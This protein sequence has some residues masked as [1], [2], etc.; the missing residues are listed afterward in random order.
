MTTLDILNVFVEFPGNLLFFLLVIALSQGSLFLA[1]GHRSRFPFEQATRRYV[2]A[3]SGL[4]IL[5]LIML[6][7]AFLTQFSALDANVYMPPMERLVYAITLLILAWCFLSADFHRWQN[8]S[9]LLVFGAAFVLVLLY[10]NSARGW[11]SEYA[12]GMA[13][14]ATVAAQL[15]SGVAAALAGFCALLAILN[16]KHIVD[17]PLKALFFFVFIIGNGWDFYQLSISDIAGNYLGAARL[18]YLAGLILL[19]VIIYRLSIALLEHSLVE[20]VLAASQ[21]NPAVAES[22]RPAQA[23]AEGEVDALLAAPSSWNFSASPIPSDRRHLLNAIGIMLETGEGVSVPEQ[24]VQAALETLQV[25]ICALLHFEENSYA[26]VIAG[27]DRVAEQSLSGVSLNLNEQPTLREAT[28]RREQTIL[29]PEYHAEELKDLYRRLSI[30][31]SSGVYAQP[32]TVEGEMVALMLVAMPYRQADLS[33]EE[34]ESLREIGYVAA[35]LLAWS[36]D[37][38]SSK[39]ITEEGLIDEIASKGNPT[40]IDQEVLNAYRHELENSLESVRDRRSRMA[41][42][43]VELKQQQEEQHVRLLDAISAGD[44]GQDMAQRLNATFD[45]QSQLRESFEASAR[46]LLDA[47]T[48]LRVLNAENAEALAQVIREYMHKEYNLL[49]TTRDRLRRQINALLMMDRSTATDGY[50]GILQTMADESAQLEL[51]REQQQRRLDSIESRLASLGLDANAPRLT[52]LLIQLYAE[53]TAY[54]RQLSEVNE[55]LDTLLTERQR[56]SDTSRGDSEDLERK[57]RNLS[58]DHEQLLDSR[59]QLRR[60]K[61]DLLAQ[62]DEARAET[63]S[64]QVTAEQLATELAAQM[65]G[66][67]EIGRRLDDMAEE[68]DNLLKL[69]DQLTAKVNETLADD[70]DHDRRADLDREVAELSASVQRLTVQREQLALELSDARTELSVAQAK[71]IGQDPDDVEDSRGNRLSVPAL[72][73][74]MLDDLRTPMTSISDYTDLL[75]AESIGIL[76][77]AQQQVLAMIAS[78]ISR[79]AELISE[80]QKVAQLDGAQIGLEYGNIDLISIIEDVIEEESGDFTEKGHI[81]ELALVDQLPPIAAD[82]ASLKHIVAQFIANASAVSPAGSKITV[83]ANFGRFQL[84]NG[85]ELIDA[86]EIKVA[87]KGGGISLDDIQ[88]V[89]ARKYRTDNREIAGFGDVG[90]GMTVARAYARAQNGDLW[91]STEAGEGSV[92]HLALPMQMDASTE[93]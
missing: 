34:L 66:Q 22:P 35:N 78:D 2:I 83:S 32:L 23:P 71:L 9:N 14:N 33:P 73:F 80:I 72:F 70:S 49:L 20:V 60:E 13:F 85:F 24:I 38:A 7:A 67:R 42:Q 53:R 88:Q 3:A 87:D 48:L 28:E 82:G 31:A 21:P 64:I 69:R 47:E 89:F 19:P 57:L 45:E 54:T 16:I 75:L 12:E 65:E 46:T 40:T 30:P 68:R 27:Y 61:Q 55:N 91:I 76:G 37:A 4:V 59:E 62:I 17:A 25:E 15:W 1:F 41:R 29:F 10:I 63:A 84:P 11:L 77:A 58:A 81:V 44:N 79:V 56:F 26:D 50:G 8:R 18:A 52:Q 93:E 51:E 36:Y 92:F 39:A 86:I 43:I 5:W 74:G 90:V 6:A